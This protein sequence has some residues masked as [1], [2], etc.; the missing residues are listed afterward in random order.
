[1]VLF[2]YWSLYLFILVSRVQLAFYFVRFFF[3]SFVLAFN[4]TSTMWRNVKFF[5][6]IKAKSMRV[7]NTMILINAN[8]E[9]SK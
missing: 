5:K 6:P 2:S 4:L 8:F 3:T 9:F 7:V 1:M